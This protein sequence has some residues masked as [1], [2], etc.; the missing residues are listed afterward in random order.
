MSHQARTPGAWLACCAAAILMLLV[1]SLGAGPATAH[2]DA[3]M[4]STPEAT[5]PTTP[6]GHD[7]GAT[8]TLP[9][10]AERCDLGFNTQGYNDAVKAGKPASMSPT[11]PEQFLGWPAEYAGMSAADKLA[12]RAQA[13]VDNEVWRGMQA[14]GHDHHALVDRWQGMTDPVACDRLKQQLR[15]VLA[16]IRKYPTLGQAQRAG[17]GLR[18][19]FFAGSG[20]HVVL[21]G[22]E[23][24]PDYEADTKVPPS[25]LYDGMGPRASVV[26][27]MFGYETTRDMNTD[28]FAGPNGEWHQHRGLCYSKNPLLRLIFPNLERFVVGSEAVS[29]RGCRSRGGTKDEAA[30]LYMMHVWVV[31]GC[32]NPHGIFA[33]DNPKLTSV[34]GIR[35]G[36]PGTR[37]C[38][39]GKAVTEPLA[40]QTDELNVPGRLTTYRSSQLTWSGGGATVSGPV[41]ATLADHP[42]AAH[43]GGEQHLAGSLA[44]EAGFAG[45]T[46]SWPIS[47]LREP[48]G[49]IHGSIG[50]PNGT[51]ATFSSATAERSEAG[52]RIATTATT[53]QGVDIAITLDLADP[54]LRTWF[55]GTPAAD[56]ERLAIHHPAHG[57]DHAAGPVTYAF[58]AH[59]GENHVGQEHLVGTATTRGGFSGDAGVWSISFLKDTATQAISGTIKNPSASKTFS[60]TVNAHHDATECSGGV[61]VEATGSEAATPTDPQNPELVI[62]DPAVTAFFA[63][64]AH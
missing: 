51:V 42:G 57:H 41:A 21:K 14:T 49:T 40:M 10:D 23:S 44:T 34:L 35:S 19:P 9:P 25:L 55:L 27:A 58:A 11:W 4:G 50:T 37:G 38:G 18:T 47:F 15:D 1:A 64:H 60:F 5:T 48:G 2:G 29:E 62:C 16:A 54:G 61:H 59:P 31:P 3:P 13:A 6:D 24:N 46:G 26:G 52:V 28:I 30:A 63:A 32:E 20:A 39:T 33:H 56:A 22:I 17:Y 7:H 43:S 12:W 45:P 36:R 53:A 8:T